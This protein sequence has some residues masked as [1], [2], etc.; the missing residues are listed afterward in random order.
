M[1]R[2]DGWMSGCTVTQ[3]HPLLLW[4]GLCMT[5]MDGQMD[6]STAAAAGGMFTTRIDGWFTTRIDGGLYC[7]VTPS[8][9]TA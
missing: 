9:A 6:G 3:S 1:T 5:R 2:I 7:H 4:R 8:T